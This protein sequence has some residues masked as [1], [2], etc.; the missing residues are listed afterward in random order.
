[1]RTARSPF[2]ALPVLLAA[3]LPAAAIVKPAGIFAS[4]MVLQR[5][6]SVPVWGTASPGELVTVAFAGQS[7]SVFAD[8]SGKWTATLAP[9]AV[10]KE[11]RTM[12]VTGENTVAF[13]N[14]LVGDVWL[15]S[16]QSN[17]EMTFGWGIYDGKDFIEEAKSLPGIR[18]VKIP[19]V[20]SLYETDEVRIQIPWGKVS[21]NMKDTTATGFFFARKLVKELDIPIGLVDDSWSGCRIEPFMPADSFSGQPLLADFEKRLARIDPAAEAGRETWTKCAADARA[22]ADKVDAAVAAGSTS[23]PL[24]QDIPNLNWVYGATGQYNA[25]VA[26]IVR[27]PI[28]GAIWYQGCSNGGEGESYRVKLSQ[29]IRGWRKAWGY[30]FPFYFVQLASYQGMSND[31]AG[32][33]GYAKIRDAMR[34]ALDVPKTGMAVT[35]D[36]GNTSDIHPKAKLFVGERLA[37]WA[38]A[39]DYGKDVVCSGPLFREQ[40]VEGDKIR[41]SFDYVGGGLMVGKK[42]NLS[43]APVEPDPDAALAGFAVC[44]ADGKWAWADAVIDGDTVVVSSKEVAEPVAVRYAFRGNPMGKCNLYN[45][46]GLP[47]SPFK[48]DK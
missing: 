47:A 8:A 23:F 48:T 35:I 20:T 46:E 37:L 19:H 4:N 44:G 3:A 18:R 27:F 29:L 22:W 14:V 25:M 1:M 10:S 33:N 11:D 26:P 30:E 32:G 9:L 2:F 45:R 15:C 39:K 6:M 16:G 41:I 42:D 34:R 31:P 24:P 17:M 5:D 36:V 28:K 43:N 13:D 7:V 40:T 21:D 12:T 38:L